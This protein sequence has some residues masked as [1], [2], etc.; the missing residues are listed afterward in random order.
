[1]LSR[2]STS[3]AVRTRSTR[4]LAS[5]GL[6]APLWLGARGAGPVPPLGPVLDPVRGAWGLA[7][8][9]AFP[10]NETGTVSGLKREVRIAYDTRAVPH[11]FAASELDGWR[12]L[13]YVTARDRLFQLDL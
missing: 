7:A 2:S 8:S 3:A 5:A 10:A 13:G 6:R 11:I 12:A 4:L 1:M 9:S